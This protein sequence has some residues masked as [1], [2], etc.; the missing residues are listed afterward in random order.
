M[1]NDDI[2]A[3]VFSY[4]ETVTCGVLERRH[5]GLVACASLGHLGSVVAGLCVVRRPLLNLH[6]I[7]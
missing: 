7:L 3:F 6:V 4:K 1:I 5:R 2:T